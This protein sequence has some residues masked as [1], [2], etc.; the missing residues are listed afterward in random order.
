MYV[1]VHSHGLVKTLPHLFRL[2][3][4]GIIPASILPIGIDGSHPALYSLGFDMGQGS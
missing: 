4:H 1:Q 3:S 2:V